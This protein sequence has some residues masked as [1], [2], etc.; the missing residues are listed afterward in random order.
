MG[1]FDTVKCEYPLPNP[2]HQDL[3]FQTKDL[4][5]GLDEY[6]ITQDGRLVRHPHRGGR[7]P[8]RDVE[9]PVHGD[10]RIY[11]ADPDKDRGFIENVVRFTHGRVEWIHPRHDDNGRKVEQPPA[12]KPMRTA[13]R[14]EERLTPEMWGR[15]LTLDE[16]HEHAPEKLELIRGEIREGEKL[17]LLV[18]TSLGL[19]RAAELVGPERWKKALTEDAKEE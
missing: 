4:E 3:S 5:I 16:Y 14:S 6:T 10:I 7:G 2:R 18:L 15:P 9:C 13:P 1:L 19:R 11:C 12:R 17:L 8:E